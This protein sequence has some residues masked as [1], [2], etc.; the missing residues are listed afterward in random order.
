M[1]HQYL[2]AS[3]S[4]PGLAYANILSRRLNVE[5]LNYGFSGSALNEIEISEIL[6][7]RSRFIYYRY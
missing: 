1:E 2:G 6:S 7:K 3:A 4:R 5:I